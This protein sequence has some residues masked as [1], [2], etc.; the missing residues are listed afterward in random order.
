M[1]FCADHKVPGAYTL[2][3]G[4]YFFFLLHDSVKQAAVKLV[5]VR[6]NR[7]PVPQDR[8]LALFIEAI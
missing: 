2:L 3:E 6:Y 5:D 4:L 1:L 8:C 7:I